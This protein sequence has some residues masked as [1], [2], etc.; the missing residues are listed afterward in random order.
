MTRQTQ[1]TSRLARNIERK[2]RKNLIFSIFGIIVVIFLVIKLGIPMLVNFSLMLSNQNDKATTTQTSS[3]PSF[4]A[5]PV[6]NPLPSATNSADLVISGTGNTG[7]NVRV[8][9]N[10]NLVDETP[11]KKDGSFSIDETLKKG[12]STIQAKSELN[13]KESDFSDS[14]TIVFNDTKP[15]LDL[16]SPSDGQT[17][18][19]DQNTA[20]V[21]GKTD[22]DV[23]ITVN[24][25]W[26][27]VDDNNNFSYSLPLQNGD[28]Q[29]KVIATDNA[30]N[31]TEKDIKVTYNP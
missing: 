21:S 23:K 7:Q 3:N 11:T 25:F 31:T 30:D 6:L 27:I 28:N 26:A 17:F 8:Y 15:N 29:I 22:P 24:G 18:S 5:P 14:L 2:T 16:T 4:I 13:G 20:P 10:N 19:K 9:I 1:R 12:T